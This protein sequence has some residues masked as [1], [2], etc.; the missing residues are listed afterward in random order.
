V[1]YQ[2]KVFDQMKLFFTFSI[3][4]FLLPGMSLDAQKISY[5]EPSKDFVRNTNFEILGRIGSNIVVYTNVRSNHDLIVFDNEMKELSRTKIDNM[6]DRLLSSEFLNLRDSAYM[7]YQYQQRNIVYCNYIKI[8]R[9][10]QPQGEHNLVDTASLKSVTGNKIFNFAFSDDKKKIVIFKIKNFRDKRFAFTTHLFNNQMQNLKTSNFDFA[11]EERND[12]LNQFY[13]DNDG[14]FIFGK[15]VRTGSGDGDNIAKF[16]LCIKKPEDDTAT[17]NWL[18]PDSKIFADDI[19]IKID[20][21]N[22]RYLMSSLYSEKKRNN[23]DGMY[24]MIWDRNKN[25][26]TGS[27]ITK[28]N[29]EQR[30][31]AKGE[32]TV[33]T[34]FNDFYLSHITV[35]KD[36]GFIVTLESIYQQNRGGNLNRWDNWG[37]LGGFNSWDYYSMNNPWGFYGNNFGNNRMGQVTRFNA[38]NIVVLSFDSA[39]SMQWSNTLRKSQWEDDTDNFLSFSILNTGDAIHYIYNSQERSITLL[40]SQSVA[41]TGKVTRNPTFRGLDKGYEFMPKYG[42]QVGGRSMVMPCLFRQSLC[43]AKLDLQ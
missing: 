40:S 11:M 18:I 1:L 28:F 16:A 17:V 23:I 4:F 32:A 33:K 15:A 42:K 12:F 29:D 31:D 39:S 6:P 30:N 35:K 22:K 34:A 10:G 7:F 27:S 2:Q 21:F 13:V 24:T 36:G 38:D 25:Q 9:N 26:Q 19:K 20:N 43:F 14:Y 41:P 5:S 8:D 3:L 37:G